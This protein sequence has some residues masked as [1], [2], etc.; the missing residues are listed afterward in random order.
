MRTGPADC[1]RALTARQVVHPSAALPWAAVSVRP[2][3]WACVLLVGV[4]ACV[5][6]LVHGLGGFACD[7]HPSGRV[8]PVAAGAPHDH[9]EAP[10][11]ADHAPCPGC[12]TGHV[13]AACLAVVGVLGGVRHLR[14]RVAH[15]IAA[16][17]GPVAPDPGRVLARLAALARAPDPP[18][19]GLSVI[20]C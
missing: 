10:D 7:G 2:A 19:L 3:R 11:P 6:V 5:L 17:R 14:R 16:V 18:W 4:A 8:G 1:A 15:A 20:R 12:V 13:M 9:G